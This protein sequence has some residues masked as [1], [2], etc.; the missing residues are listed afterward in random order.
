MKKII[1]CIV[2]LSPSFAFAQ[3]LNDINTVAAK[4]TNIGNL[5][6][7]III[8]LSV[9]WIIISAFRYFIAGGEEDRAK[10]GMAVLFGVIGLF[11]IL[12]VWGLVYLLKNS[13]TFSRNTAPTEEINKIKNQPPV[14]VPN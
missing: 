11:V 9:I 12:S 14:V 13:F 5:V 7:E 8:A 2:A 1:A 4:A 6:V 10:G 3:Q